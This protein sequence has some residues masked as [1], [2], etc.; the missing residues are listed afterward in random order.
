[1]PLA[2]PAYAAGFFCGALLDEL[3]VDPVQVTMLVLEG[4]RIV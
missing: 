4:R 2:S 1:V 3:G